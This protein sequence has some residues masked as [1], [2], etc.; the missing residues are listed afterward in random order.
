MNAD[1]APT[2]NRIEFR[3]GSSFSGPV[4]RADGRLCLVARGKGLSIQ[5][6]PGQLRA[7]ARQAN[8]VAALLEEREAAAAEEAAADLRRLSAGSLADGE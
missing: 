8:A 2:V 1:E 6:R 4:L 7:L 3:D 5:L